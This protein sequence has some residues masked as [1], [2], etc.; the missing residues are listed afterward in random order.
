MQGKLRKHRVDDCLW[1]SGREEA[2]S[3]MGGQNSGLGPGGLA[4]PGEE[5][6]VWT[7]GNGEP[8]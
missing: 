4:C 7:A 8:L 6:G 5:L 3:G 1:S 2:H